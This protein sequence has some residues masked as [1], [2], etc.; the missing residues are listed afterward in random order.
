[1]SDGVI[2]LAADSSWLPFAIDA[3]HRQ[4]EQRPTLSARETD[5][6]DRV[7]NA[8][9]ANLVHAADAAPDTVIHPC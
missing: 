7:D 1:V 5:H 6:S 4:H 9:A 2:A 8:C 3:T